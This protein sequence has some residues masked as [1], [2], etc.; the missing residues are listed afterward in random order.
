MC[1]SALGSQKRHGCPVAGTL[2]S[3]KLPQES[4]V[5][6]TQVLNKSST[7]DQTEWERELSAD[8]VRWA[9]GMLYR[10]Q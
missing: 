9:T 4:A 8:G 3:C 7:A 1:T 6:W 2:N 10:D 5:N